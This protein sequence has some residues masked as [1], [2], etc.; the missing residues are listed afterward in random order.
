L[1]SLAGGLLQRT[2]AGFD[3]MDEALRQRLAERHPA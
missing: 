1:V 2:E 3:A